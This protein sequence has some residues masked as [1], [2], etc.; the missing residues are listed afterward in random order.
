MQK[1]NEPF[2]PNNSQGVPNL[3]FLY[4]AVFSS[5]INLLLSTWLRLFRSHSQKNEKHKRVYVPELSLQ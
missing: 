2:H 5:L 3:P 1:L 4:S